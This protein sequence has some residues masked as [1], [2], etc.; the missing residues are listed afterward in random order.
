MP[1]IIDLTE[2]L[3]LAE[4][5]DQVIFQ[6]PDYE[7]RLIKTTKPHIKTRR[8][9]RYSMWRYRHLRGWHREL[10]EYVAM[11]A[12]NGAPCDRLAGLFGFCQTSLG[13][14]FVVEK[15][16]TPDG[17]LAPTLK[18]FLNTPGHSNKTL[19]QLR[20]DVIDLFQ[21]L[22]THRI[23]FHDPHARNVV[24]TGAKPLLR[25]VDGIGSAPLIPMTQ[26]SDWA[27]RRV[28][29]QGKARLLR[30]VDKAL[31]R[32]ARLQQAQDK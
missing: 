12:R 3:P 32:Q 5:R 22:E 23:D 4:G 16:S 15:I 24:V 31:A 26:F 10:S 1:Q 2:A 13:P 27:F 11:L 8:I 30:Q 21:A 29:A 14:G 17:S 6:H 7:D 28:A 9:K 19:T 18:Q 20:G 25:I